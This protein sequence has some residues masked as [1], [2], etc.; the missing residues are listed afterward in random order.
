MP[1]PLAHQKKLPPGAESPG[2]APLVEAELAPGDCL[3]VPRGSR[4]ACT[5]EDGLPAPDRGQCS[6]TTG[7][8]C[9]ARWVELATEER[10]GSGR[11]CRWG[12]KDE[13]GR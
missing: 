12:S 9:C 7:T 1:F 5:A 8:S 10:P 6:P 3:Y 11:A 4:A 13:P 2:E